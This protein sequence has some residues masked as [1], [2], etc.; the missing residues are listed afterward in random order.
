M[1]DRAYQDALHHE[2]PQHILLYGE[3]GSGKT[4]AVRHLVDHLM[5]MGK[6]KNSNGEN[7]DRALHVIHAFTN[8]STPTNYDSTRC[9]MRTQIVY[10]S[11]G[12]VSGAMFGV[13]QL[14][15]WRVSSTDM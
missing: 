5:Y 14:E 10:G 7:I 1:A 11:T 9:V 4:T 8:A 13:Y 3:S 6:S 15:K 12:K 2:A